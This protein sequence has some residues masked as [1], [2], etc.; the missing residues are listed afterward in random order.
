[1]LCLGVKCVDLDF[2][3]CVD[4]FLFEV[5][6]CILVSWDDGV[7]GVEVVSPEFSWEVYALAGVCFFDFDV[8]VV[9]VVVVVV[10]FFVIVVFVVDGVEDC[11][12]KVFGGTCDCGGLYLRCVVDGEDDVA[13]GFLGKEEG[14]RVVVI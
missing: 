9:V 7:T 4:E 5:L 11:R 8:I 12:L 13:P 10:D 1:M 2:A 14:L 6:E 3:T